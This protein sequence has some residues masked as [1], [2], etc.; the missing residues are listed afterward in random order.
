M[1]LRMT[2]ISNLRPRLVDYDCS[3]SFCVV[4]CT[5]TALGYFMTRNDNH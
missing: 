1:R 5:I 2:C 3:W 4:I